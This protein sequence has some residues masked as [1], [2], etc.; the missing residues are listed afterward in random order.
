MSHT[1]YTAKFEQMITHQHVLLPL[2]SQSY[3]WSIRNNNIAW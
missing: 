1:N 2:E 3:W